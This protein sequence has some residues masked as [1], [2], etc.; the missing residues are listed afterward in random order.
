[1]I[2]SVKHVK[3]VNPWMDIQEVS[4]SVTWTLLYHLPQLKQNKTKQKKKSWFQKI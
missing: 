4:Q 1:M 2:N 3:H